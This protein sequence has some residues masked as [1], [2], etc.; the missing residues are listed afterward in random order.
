MK[1]PMLIEEDTVFICG[2]RGKE[3]KIQAY[4]AFEEAEKQLTDRGIKC[5]N[6]Y[7]LFEGE[8]HHLLDEEKH[9]NVI[10][11]HLAMCDMIVTIPGW[12]NALNSQIEINVARHL[13]K[14]IVLLDKL[15]KIHDANHG[16]AIAG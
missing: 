9:M 16:N 7:S 12:Q 2:P 13:N 15:L 3:N 11:S 1:N 4:Q 5:I 8:E 6:P 10:C 14:A